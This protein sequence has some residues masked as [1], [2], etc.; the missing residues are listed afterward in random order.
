M[1]FEIQKIPNRI[2]GPVRHL[3]LEL[4]HDSVRQTTL[5]DARMVN[6]LSS[7]FLHSVNC[8][9]GIS[10]HGF[11]FPS[12]TFRCGRSRQV[13][14][15]FEFLNEIFLQGERFQFCRFGHLAHDGLCHRFEF[16]D[17]DW[18]CQRSPWESLP[19]SVPHC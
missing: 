5:A 13:R 11:W 15:R 14:P 4:F 7:Y 9:L 17:Q 12:M 3:E 19:T 2:H 8:Y 6:C 10:S 1:L 16:G 18:I